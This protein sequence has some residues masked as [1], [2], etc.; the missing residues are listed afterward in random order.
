MH[1][2]S[3]SHV[4]LFVI[5][6]GVAHQVPLSVEFTSQEYWSVCYF[7]LHGIFPAQES[8]PHLLH[9]LY[10]QVDFLPHTHIQKGHK[11][12]VNVWEV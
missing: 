12:P 7:L 11:I 1:A 2:Q 10:W 4:Q 5:P 8:N 9:L 3:F 6:W